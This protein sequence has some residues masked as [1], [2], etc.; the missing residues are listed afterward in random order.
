MSDNGGSAMPP[1]RA[2]SWLSPK[3]RVGES[4]IQGRGLFAVEPFPAGEVVKVLGGV[5]MDDVEF[6]RWVAGRERFDALAIE[7][8]LNLILPEGD[9]AGLGNHSCDPN[10][11]MADEVTIVARRDIAP[12][13]ELTVDYALMTVHEDWSMPC[14]CGAASC[15]GIVTGRDWRRPQLQERYPEQFSPFINRRIVE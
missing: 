10:T 6:R 1:Y 15:R 9:P 14:H 3:V 7:E 8:G 2:T 11:V 4:P 12:G 5:V 13:E